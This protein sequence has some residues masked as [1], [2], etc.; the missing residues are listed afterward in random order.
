MPGSWYS[1]GVKSICCLFACAAVIAFGQ[2]PVTETAREML[3]AHNV[4]RARVGVPALIWSSQLESLAQKWADALI[5]S[6]KFEHSL[7]SDYGENLFQIRGART[8]ATNVVEA[9]SSE[10]RNYDHAS[11]HCRTGA[12]CGHYTQIVWRG[13]KQVGC[14]SSS[15]AKRQVWVCMYNPPGNWKGQ[16]P[17]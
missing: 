5:A 17:Y 6:G 16:S 15:A 13:T 8:S 12:A 11:N 1:T 14:A 7:H 9:W 4:V 3:T 10:V 2:A